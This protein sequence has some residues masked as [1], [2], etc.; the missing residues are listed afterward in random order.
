MKV[1][2]KLFLFTFISKYYQPLYNSANPKLNYDPN[3]FYSQLVDEKANA[4][5]R[6]FYEVS[7]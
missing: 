4:S 5:D 3:K 1:L 2:G 6:A 7:E